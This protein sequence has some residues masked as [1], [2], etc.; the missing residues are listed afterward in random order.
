MKKVRV[1]PGN[2]GP[3]ALAPDFRRWRMLQGMLGAGA[4]ALA[5]RDAGAQSRGLGPAAEAGAAPQGSGTG[6]LR[7]G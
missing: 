6:L 5:G 2:G 1:D 4:L 3:A 7:A